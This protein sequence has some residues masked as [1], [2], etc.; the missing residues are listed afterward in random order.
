MKN[1][2]DTVRWEEA[3]GE[4]KRTQSKMKEIQAGEHGLYME[5][6]EKS[7]IIH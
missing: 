2:E 1:A 6:N 3:H 5:R 7:N 4:V